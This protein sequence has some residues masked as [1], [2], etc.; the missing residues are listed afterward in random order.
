ME[1][2]IKQIQYYPQEYLEVTLTQ[3]IDEKQHVY[4]ISNPT[5]LNCFVHLSSPSLL[6]FDTQSYVSLKYYLSHHVIKKNE[7]KQWC[8]SVLNQCESSQNGFSLT[9]LDHIFVDEETKT[10]H[11]CKIPQPIAINVNETIVKFV[12]SLYETMDYDGDDEWISQMYLLVKQRPFRLSL[13]KQFL[14]S[15]RHRRWLSFFRKDEEDLSEFFKI[16]QVRESEPVYSI[17]TV[18]FETQ[19]LMA[20]YQYGY[21][22]DERQQKILITSSPWTIGRQKT[23]HYVLEFPE[24][25]KQHCTLI[26]EN[27][28]C[29]VI[30]EASTNGTTLNSQKLIGKEKVV[31]KNEDELI[32]AG[33]KFIYYV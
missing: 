32:L 20:G 26:V 6:Y 11:F 3:S 28:C 12:M 33:H 1:K 31:L 22:L 2:L 21:L 9:Q 17:N 16:I 27:G 19:V 13:F 15:K 8:L 10:L 18:P 23:C 30:D 4:F 7:V 29:Y 5:L 14:E 24:I 25:S